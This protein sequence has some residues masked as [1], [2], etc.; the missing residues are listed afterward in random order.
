MGFD[1]GNNKYTLRQAF[2]TAGKEF[3]VIDSE[4]FSVIVPYGE[5][6]DIITKLCG[7]GSKSQFDCGYK[8]RLVNQAKRYSVSLFKYQFERLRG[9]GA[10]N[11]IV[12]SGIYALDAN[13]YDD[14]LGVYENG[15][16]IKCDILML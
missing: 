13:Y 14:A 1:N 3:D 8:K 4:T 10:I 5:G 7:Y 15:G 11:E 12:N 2:A 9:I 16:G 6:R